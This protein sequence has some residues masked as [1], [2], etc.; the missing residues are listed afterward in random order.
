MKRIIV[1]I[2]LALMLMMTVGTSVVLA[3][4]PPDSIV[5]VVGSGVRLDAGGTDGVLPCPHKGYHSLS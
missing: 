5:V 4:G 1:S 3:K 2:L